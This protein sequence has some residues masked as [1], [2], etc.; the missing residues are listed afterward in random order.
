MQK[1]ILFYINKKMFFKIAFLSLLITILIP[2]YIFIFH[3]DILEPLLNFKHIIFQF[4]L[5]LFLIFFLYFITI[6][7]KKILSEKKIEIIFEFLILWV[8]TSGL[9]IPVAGR[10]DPFFNKNFYFTN[11]IILVSELVILIFVF[12]I[13]YKKNV[14]HLLKKFILSYSILVFFLT[15]FQLLNSYVNEVPADED[16]SI[17]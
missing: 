3:L 5:F 9:I 11:F 15:S 17:G 4:N 13:F 8:F 10:F 14:I 6:F 7:L 1:E 16:I 12:Y 2:N